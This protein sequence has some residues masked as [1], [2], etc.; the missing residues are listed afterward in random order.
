[1]VITADTYTSVLPLA[2]RS[3]AGTTAKLVL[4]AAH[5]TREKIRKNGRRNRPT[6]RA[7]TG[8]PGPAGPS[9]RKNPQ[10]K[11]QNPGTSS[12]K[13]TTAAWHPRDTTVHTGQP[14]KDIDPLLPQVKRL[15]IL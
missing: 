8:A 7:K 13:V 3:C 10:L 1:M 9:K 11:Q 4:A 12:P 6:P 14:A 5:R 15:V 2:Q